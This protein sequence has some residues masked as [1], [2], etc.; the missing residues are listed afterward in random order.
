M[1]KEYLEQA[2]IK[3]QDDLFEVIKT[4]RWKNTS[5]K[6][7][8]AAKT[9]YIRGGAF[10]NPINN[11]LKKSFKE[12]DNN[13]EFK[14]ANDDTAGEEVIEGYMKRKKQDL[15]IRI[16]SNKDSKD[17]PLIINNRTQM[18]KISANWDTIFE[19]AYAEALNLRSPT[20]YITGEV[21]LLPYY[22]M[23]YKKCEENIIEYKTK[24]INLDWFFSH[25]AK[26]NLRE[27]TS[28]EGINFLKYDKLC[29]LIVDFKETPAKIVTDFGDNNLNQRYREFSYEGFCE[30]L[31]NKYKNK[32]N[33]G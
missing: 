1:H 32:I 24:P 17:Y 9:A 22:E 21:F 11:V 4:G 27:D 29:I 5:Y 3:M 14:P 8:Q 7:G 6:N 15:T 13:L 33:A 19:R 12:I 18:S 25:Y 20:N 30:Y 2:L 28:T 31:L 10:I 16:K 26:V 23:D